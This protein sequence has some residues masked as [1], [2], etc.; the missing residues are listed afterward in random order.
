[1]SKTAA[2]CLAGFVNIVTAPMGR[3]LATATRARTVQ[4]LTPQVAV[5]TKR[6][7]LRFH[8]PDKTS[9]YWPRA[10]FAD[11]PGTIAWLDGITA[12]DVLWDIGAN[13]GSYAMYAALQDGVRVVAFEPNPLTFHSL[14]R[15]VINNRLSES[16]MPLCMALSGT[17]KL[18]TLA[19]SGD[20]AGSVFN[21][22]GGDASASP[23][24]VVVPGMSVD[25]FATTFGPPL[26]THMKIDVDNIEAEIVA[27]A[28]R[29]LSNPALRSVLIEM[30][31]ED[32][33]ASERIR[34][35]LHQAGLVES[36]VERCPNPRWFNQI[37]TRP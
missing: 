22:F 8:T 9:I 5:T 3:W 2:A 37:F 28:A 12:G 23:H 14:A 1:M 31:G 30:D 26:P 24:R 27:G 4:K 19:L 16:L 17:T 7:V 10:S 20:E 6:G 36:S 13:V 35:L 15:N 34:Q 29:T 11:E 25:D 33:G 32:S 21:S 18:A